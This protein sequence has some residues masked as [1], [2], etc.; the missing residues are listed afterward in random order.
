MLDGRCLRCL[1]LLLADDANGPDDA[2]HPEFT[3]DRIG[4]PAARSHR[5][6]SRRFARRSR[7][8]CGGHSGHWRLCDLDGVQRSRVSDFNRDRRNWQRARQ[9]SRHRS[10]QDRRAVRRLLGRTDDG[11]TAVRGESHRRPRPHLAERAEL[12][13]HGHHGHAGVEV[14]PNVKYER[15]LFMEHVRRT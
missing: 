14:V 15:E 7:K 5:S 8:D 3:R 1:T 2:D 10:A 6:R 13:P 9:P 4:R 12:Q 11:N